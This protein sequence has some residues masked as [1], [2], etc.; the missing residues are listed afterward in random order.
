M[1]RTFKYVDKDRILPWID[2]QLSNL[3]NHYKYLAALEEIKSR[4]IDGQFDWQP[5]E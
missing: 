3:E 2:G 1:P 5:S 4:I